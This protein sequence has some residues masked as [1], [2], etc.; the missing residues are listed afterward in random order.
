MIS[1]R[2]F[3]IQLTGSLAAQNSVP[4]YYFAWERSL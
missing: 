1:L 2:A 3:S 4:F